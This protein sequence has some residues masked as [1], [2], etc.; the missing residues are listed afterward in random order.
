M[1]ITNNTKKLR[2]ILCLFVLPTFLGLSDSA[3]SSLISTK[4]TADLSILNIDEK[5]WTDA[6][7]EE[8]QL[9]AQPMIAPRPKETTTSKILVQS[10]NDGKWIAF[11]LRW[12]DPE[13]SE[14]GKPGEFSDAVAIE[15]PV[16]DGPPPPVFM[17]AKDQPVHLFHWRAQYQYDAEKGKKEMKDIYP[18]MNVDMYPMEF[19]DSGTLGDTSAGREQYVQGKAAGNPQ[20][21]A[22]TGVD[23]IFAEGFST[24]A[25]I[26]NTMNYG[27]GRWISGEWTVIIG[28]PLVREEASKLKADQDNFLGFAVWQGGKDEVG[29]RKSLT[30]SWVPLQVGK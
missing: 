22:K 13:R 28:R 6:K 17:G 1:K 11:R 21:Y 30:M 3:Y 29:S 10:I 14:A 7:V 12:K 27:S 25:V 9:T 8:V 18:N 16:K 19:N 5:T 15:F 24:S 26:Q 20:S 4:T 2:T 23:E